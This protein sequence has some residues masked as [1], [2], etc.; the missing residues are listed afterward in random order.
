MQYRA[1]IDGLRAVAVLPVLFF[2]A[3]VPYFS[4]GFVG[5]DVFFVISGYV[6]TKGLRA[7]IES[8]HFS[9]AGFYERRFRRI[10]P[11]LV[12]TLCLTFAAALFLLLPQELVDLSNSLIASVLSVSN[13][14][15]WRSSSYF[16]A[17]SLFRPL[18]HTWSLSVEEQFYILMPLSMAASRYFFERTWRYLFWPVLLL[19][20]LLSISATYTAPTANFYLLPTRAWEI[21]LGAML[22]LTPPPRPAPWLAELLA[23]A[24]LALIGFCV[25]SYSDATP[26]PGVSAL[27]P[28]IGSFLVIFAGADN[29]TR[30]GRILSVR[31]LVLVGLI[32]YSLYLVH[33]PITVMMRYYLLQ[34]PQALQVLFIIVASFVLAIL[35]W[36]FIETPFRRG[37][38]AMTRKAVFASW[39]TA[40]AFLVILGSVG[41]LSAGFP[42]RFPDMQVAAAAGPGLWRNGV[43][44]LDGSQTFD[45]WDA[46]KCALTHG[47]SENVLL[48]GDS[49]AAHYVPGIIAY[50]T[51]LNA[52][53]YQYTAAG[54][55]PVL[56]YYSYKLPNC[57][58]FNAHALEIIK[59]LGIR[60]V[61]LSA[62]WGLLTTRGGFDLRDTIRQIEA[63]GADVFVFGQSPEFGIDTRALA[64]R[65]KERSDW[66]AA[67]YDEAL[68]QKIRL[69]SEGAHYI[70]PFDLL[71]EKTLCSFKTSAGLLYIDYGHFSEKGSLAAVKSIFPLIS[72]VEARTS[73]AH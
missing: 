22:V 6:I 54:C 37:G 51:Q 41:T 3:G 45:K 26:F 59:Q 61:I 60:K 23:A 28:C 71:C 40:V 43:C 49:F 53:I 12:A 46:K 70:S 2:H 5:V 42:A 19:S 21:L 68:E 66:Y 63:A 33:W 73:E 50:G 24:G 35:S 13:I 36:R 64:V 10:F 32:S 34:N 4:G 69:Q 47:Y 27:L 29:A 20:L 7:E 57:Q 25:F 52:N 38:A 14:Y 16:D 15:F 9:I 72:G 31:P 39:G 8:G 67:N 44:F 17:S 11:A 55:P 65:L 1:D 30:V 58:A 56:K 48:W 18:L 62:R